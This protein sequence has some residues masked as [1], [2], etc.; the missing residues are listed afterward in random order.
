[1]DGT[2]AIKI[3]YYE[4][5]KAK[6]DKYDEDMKSNEVRILKNFIENMP[7][8]YRKRNMNFTI[9]RDI[10]MAGTSTAGRTSCCKKCIELGIEPYSYEL[11]EIEK[12]NK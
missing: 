8:V 10:L 6:A 4:E 9:V 3:D 2:T 12:V 7:K 1:M 5:L 11:F